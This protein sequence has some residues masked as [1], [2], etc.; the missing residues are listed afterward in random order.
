MNTKKSMDFNLKNDATY[1]FN[2]KK[3]NNPPCW[4]PT[5]DNNDV[6]IQLKIINDKNYKSDN[7]ILSLETLKKKSLEDN[8]YEF[9]EEDRQGTIDFN[10]FY[11]FMN[12]NWSIFEANC[13]LQNAQYLW[14]KY[15]GLNNRM[16][17]YQFNGVM[18]I[19]KVEKFKYRDQVGRIFPNFMDYSDYNKIYDYYDKI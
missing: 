8:T 4:I 17:Y 14:N 16:D 15:V 19:L 13:K 10:S 5:D 18:R 9:T 1:K 3:C 7:D 2:K 6:F 12:D 11:N